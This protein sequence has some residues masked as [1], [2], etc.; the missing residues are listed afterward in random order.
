MVEWIKCKFEIKEILKFL[1]GGGSAVVV[2]A[3]FYAILK[4]YR[5]FCR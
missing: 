2:D 3:L 1:V 5:F 4:A